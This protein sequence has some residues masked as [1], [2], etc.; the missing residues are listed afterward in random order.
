MPCRSR[1]VGSYVAGEA[2]N[3]A[4]S[5]DAGPGAPVVVSCQGSHA[6]ADEAWNAATDLSRTLALAHA[7]FLVVSGDLSQ[8]ASQGS[9]GNDTA[10]TRIGQLI[11]L[12]QSAS[13]PI[14]GRA[15][16]VA[17]IG[18]SGGATA[19]INYARANPANV[20]ALY[21]MTPLLDLQDFHDNRVTQA[22]SSFTQAEIEAAYGGSAAYAAAVASHS[23]V[24]GSNP[25][26]LAGIPI[27]LAYSTNDQYVTTASVDAFAAATG[28]QKVS[29]GNVLHNAASVDPA[30][31]VD[32]L[33]R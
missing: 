11:T 13:A 20:S 6:L 1:G 22:G 12:A 18:V 31:V 16:K 17:L 10:R 5:K 21:L 24:A 27:K 30:D 23:P 29:L 14:R 8:T 2:H 32:F 26:Q 25:A 7:G 4:W 15:G 9:F 33:R 19:A 3:F 28:A